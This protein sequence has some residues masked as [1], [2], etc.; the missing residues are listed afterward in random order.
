VTFDA[1]YYQNTGARRFHA[2]NPQLGNPRQFLP[3]QSC[4]YLEDT[5]T[6]IGR[7]QVWGS[8]WQPEFCDWAF[9]LPRKSKEIG[10]K[11]AMIPEGTSVLITHGP[12]HGRLGGV[13][14]DGFDAGCELLRERVKKVEPLIH[15]CGHIHEGYG[16]YVLGKTMV[17]NASS[18][19]LSYRPTNPPVIF[20]IVDKV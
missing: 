6:T 13:C 4:T 3:S 7:A 2:A 5:G 16:C 11:W 15:V 12:P 20:D 8:P 9:N 1:A 18:V 17:I 10:S 19:N 14:R